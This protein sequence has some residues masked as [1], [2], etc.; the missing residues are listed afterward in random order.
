MNISL[1][2][3]IVLEKVLIEDQDQDTLFYIGNVRLQIDSLE[4]FRRKVHFGDLDFE[5]SKINILKGKTG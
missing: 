2:K 5:D 1:F 4:F 3:S